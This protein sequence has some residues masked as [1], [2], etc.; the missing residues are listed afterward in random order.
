M[1][2]AENFEL[3]TGFSDCNLTLSDAGTFRSP[4]GYL[5]DAFEPFLFS[6]KTPYYAGDKIL[7]ELN[8]AHP[9]SRLGDGPTCSS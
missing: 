6:I 1:L 7:V 5:S 3:K 8:Q 2:S 9:C 4:A